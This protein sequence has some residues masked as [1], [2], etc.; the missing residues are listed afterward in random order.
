MNSSSAAFSCGLSLAEG[1][2]DVAAVVHRDVLVDD[3]LRKDLGPHRRHMAVD[4]DGGQ[5]TGI[6]H[7]QQVLVLQVLGG[8]NE[9]DRLAAGSRQ[10]G[11]QA[12]EMLPVARRL[13]HM[14]LEAG[15]IVRRLQGRRIRAS[16]DEL[17]D[18]GKQ[19][20]REIHLRLQR[21]GDREVGRGDVAAPCDQGRDQLIVRDRD[22]DDV[23]LDV[24]GLEAPVG[25]VLERLERVVCD[26]ARRVLVDEVQRAVGY[27]EHAHE[28]ALDDGVPVT[29]PS[30]QRRRVFQSCS[31]RLC[32]R[33]QSNRR[34][35]SRHDERYRGAQH[36]S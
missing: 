2:R 31:R 8:R 14:Q 7:L 13:V 16:D 32:L 1:P 19:R 34:S 36:R 21:L 33:G 27:D 30:A 5:Q 20:R 18:P 15:H 3:D 25:F 29:L 6:H 9:S 35:N 12:F 28:P 22:E 23:E 24:F 11:V 4:D 17:A 26:P 10:A